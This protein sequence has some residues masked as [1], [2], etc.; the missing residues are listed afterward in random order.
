M[1]LLSILVADDDPQ[2][3][4]Y[5][6][7][8][9]RHLGHRIQTVADGAEAISC[10]RARHFDVVLMD[11]HMPTVDGLTATQVIRSEPLTRQPVILAL[12]ADVRSPNRQA[13]L[14]AGMDGFISK[15]V[16]RRDLEMALQGLQRPH[17]SPTP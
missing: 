4:Q 17:H 12:S 3:R 15:P 2:V 13:C 16:R 11:C 8:T 5:L 6:Q 14:D 10:I 1:S 7:I 9:L